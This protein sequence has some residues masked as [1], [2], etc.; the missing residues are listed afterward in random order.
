MVVPQLCTFLVIPHPEQ[1]E[2]KTRVPQ[3]LDIPTFFL[4]PSVMV[5]IGNLIIYCNQPLLCRVFFKAC[6]FHLHFASRTPK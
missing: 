5:D 6:A 3:H 4:I 2:V 1:W